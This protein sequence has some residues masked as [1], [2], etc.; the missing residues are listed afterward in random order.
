MPLVSIGLPVYNGEEYLAQT[1][2][3]LLTQTFTDF[4]LIISDNASTDGTEQ[5]CRRY[6][7]NDP[8]IRYSRNERNIGA[9]GNY[10]RVFA[11]S[12]G[13]YFKWAAHDDLCGPEY[14]RR[15]VAVLET[16]PP[17]VLCYTKTTIIDESGA[18]AQHS[19]DSF[20]LSSD[21]PSERLR[22]CFL[23]G[24]W[25]FQPVF[26]VIRRETLDRT[27][28]I[29]NYVGSDLVLLARVAL[30]G[31]IHEV[32]E[33]LFF[34]REHAKRSGN[35]SPDK[36]VK[37]WNPDNRG[38]LYLPNWRRFIEYLRAVGNAGLSPGEACLSYIH[39]MRWLW[40]HRP[41]LWRDLSTAA[42]KIQRLP[43]SAFRRR[44]T[45]V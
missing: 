42:M 15:C 6:A 20:H 14:L 32:P 43:L 22:D 12:T 21:R 3:S 41:I 5:I 27:P 2:E 18:P 24:S 17:V 26:G 13:K 40:W 11:L 9:G 7:A 33:R 31:R 4:E 45:E 25:I 1:I 8:R 38:L 39:V 44:T 35:L 37:W 19:E 30:A 29:A 16:T 23:A 10:N 36:F 34:R 28:L